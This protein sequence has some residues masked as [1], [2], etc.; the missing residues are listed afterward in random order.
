[1]E[2][3]NKEQ[4]QA[5]LATEGPL[6]ILAG[7]GSG[8]TGTMTHRIAHLI[9][10]VGIDPYNILAVTFTN[11]AA[12]EM[13]ERVTSILG[14]D[15]NMWIMTF[16]AACLRILRRNAEVIGYGR[17]F[18][19]YDPVDTKSLIKKILKE[20]NVDDKKFTPVAMLSEISHQKE[21]EIMPKDYL[22]FTDGE[23]RARIISNIYERYVAAMKKSNAMD[24][25]DLLLNTVN[26]FEADEDV[27]EFYQNRF[28]YIMVDEYQDTNKIQYKFISMLAARHGNLC[29]VGDDDQCI[30]QWRGADIT[31]ILNFEKD[32]P[33]ARVIKLEQNYRSTGNILAA[34][35]SVIQNNRER[36]GKKLW[37]SQEDGAKICYRRAEDEKDEAGYVA[38]EIDRLKMGGGRYSDFAILYRTNSQSRNF[39]EALSRRGIPYRVV[40]GIRYYDRKEIKDIV[41]Y[42]RLVMNP[43]DDL[44]LTRV[45]NEPKRGIGLTTVNKLTALA[46]A[47]GISV[48]E[49]LL[50]VDELSGISARAKKSIKEFVDLL[51]DCHMS[52]E[53]MSVSEIYDQLLTGSGYLA[54]L[55]D[56]NNAESD[57]RIENLLEFKSVIADYEKDDKATISDFLEGIA[58]LSDIDNYDASEDSVSLMT[59]HSAKGLE[60]PYVFLVGMEDG[61]FPGWRSMDD[62]AK[63]E[64][65]RRLCYVGMTR[66]K[67]RLCLTGA[68]Y[69]TLYGK[70]SFTR[71]STFM[72]ELDMKLVEGDG[73]MERKSESRLGSEKP[74]DGY[75]KKDPYRPFDRLTQAKRTVK[76]S[77]HRDVNY[78]VG[79]VVKH[80]KFGEGTVIDSE[81]SVVTVAFDSVGIKK[82]AKSV[83]PLTK[84]K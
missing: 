72:R 59:M 20:L 28:K 55:E 52:M 6:L 48:F 27:L 9:K 58:L 78:T 80:S 36:K 44:S 68:E 21:Q 57:A 81:G 65:E 66:A 24:F 46:G 39:E 70:G 10:N 12:G 13:R 69:R 61:L 71:E 19:V 14:E 15:V 4:K 40:G 35:H 5:V 23:Y 47:Q 8:K 1:M 11:K 33:G 84:V 76:E 29:V 49:T 63:M 64:E 60:F 34:A 22:A 38:Q 18:V 56:A 16:H 62:S 26:I 2:N 17:D 37:T 32:F 53:D 42:M 31:N 30:Y 67:K 74:F 54:A 77:V 43:K 83:A 25:D 45:I 75:A 73:V 41:A 51:K 7:A 82:L 79:E 50:D 3:L